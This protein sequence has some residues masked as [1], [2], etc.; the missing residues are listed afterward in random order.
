MQQRL[1][2]QESNWQLLYMGCLLKPL[3]YTSHG[4]LFLISFFVVHA[5][6][7]ARSSVKSG[8]AES[9][10]AL[11]LIQSSDSFFLLFSQL[12]LFLRHTHTHY[13]DL[14]P[15]NAQTVHQYSIMHD[16]NGAWFTLLPYK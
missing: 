16:M 2:S 7:L 9:C 11:S 13:I 1:E 15:L 8:T 10:A 4:S 14:S 6:Y 3:G 5:V 12:F